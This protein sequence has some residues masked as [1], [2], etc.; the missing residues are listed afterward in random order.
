[1]IARG[2]REPSHL[3]VEELARELAAL[4]GLLVEDCES[5]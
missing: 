4:S 2:V 3:V 1:M 5:P